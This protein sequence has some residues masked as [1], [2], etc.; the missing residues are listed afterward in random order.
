MKIPLLQQA[1][2]PED[3]RKRGHLL[4]DEL[5]D[6]L[7]DKL[8]AKTSK[9]I[10]WNEPEFELQFWKD[11]LET[12]R[13]ETLFS[14]ITKRTTYVHHPHYIGH[15]VSPT[16]PITALTGAISSLLNNGMAVYE[17]GMAS[18]AIERVVTDMLC[19]QIGYDTNSRGFLTSGGT[20]ANLTALLG[21]RKAVLDHD[22]WTEGHSKPLG[23][24][25]SSEAHY[26]VERAAKI[27]GLGEQGIIKIPVTNGYAMDVSQLKA[28][29]DEAASKGVEIFAIIGSAPSTATG[30]YDDL[31]GIGQ[32]A[33][34][35]N[36]WFHVDGAHGGAAIF[37]QK[38]SHT[39]A[40]M[41]QADSVVIDGHKMMMM[42]TITTALL[43][44]NGTNASATFSQ[45]ADYLLTQEDHEDWYNSG[46]RT[47]EC[48][49]NMMSIH[50]YTLLKVYGVE[51]FDE[52]VTHLY[53]MGY[54][55]GEII[56][57]HPDFE[58]A[59]TPVSNIVCF[60]YKNDA[61][62]LASLNKLNAALRRALL[63]EGEYYIVQT[64]LQGIH[65]L[66]VTVMNPFTT[67]VH[68]Q[69][70]LDK[71]IEWVLGYPTVQA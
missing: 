33:K 25:V 31:K 40:G 21:A 30:V 16:A 12:G 37:S 10:H 70:L 32:F 5:A 61:L 53:D 39:V 14:E 35:H 15:Q 66:R 23:I 51:I 54:L 17:M 38:Y 1:Y 7:D 19:K 60:R 18:S 67:E 71:V 62:D 42:P 45:K 59:V 9:A 34:A 43:M 22:V 11:F 49:K 55:F 36:L 65:Y 44:K 20:L 64:K 50:W 52:F 41:D 2:S 28:R 6:H 26:C 69:R 47:F 48:T 58:L 13:E 27:M 56:A 57:N 46:K 24:M 29:F 63:E 8:K 4:I 3:F 68:F